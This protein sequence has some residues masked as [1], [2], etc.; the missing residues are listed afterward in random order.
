MSEEPQD[1]MPLLRA[2]FPGW[3]DQERHDVLWNCT[4][5]PCAGY[6]H[7]KQQLRRLRTK[8]INGATADELIGDAERELDAAMD[9]AREQGE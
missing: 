4:A 3:T 8:A 9:A 6:E 7:V 2:W 1:L 5:Y